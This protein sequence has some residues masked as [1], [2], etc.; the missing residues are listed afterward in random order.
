MTLRF[1]EGEDPTQELLTR[2]VKQ[3]WGLV[4]LAPQR[5]S[6]EEVFVQLTCGEDGAHSLPARERAA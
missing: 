6:L 2:A 4:E 5:R 1:R 3:D